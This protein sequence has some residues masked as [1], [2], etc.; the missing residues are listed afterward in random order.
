MRPILL[1]MLSG[2]LL[3][4]CATYY[5]Y[6]GQIYQ[7]TGG[8]TYYVLDPEGQ[9]RDAELGSD[10]ATRVIQQ[11]REVSRDEAFEAQSVRRDAQILLQPGTPAPSVSTTPN[12]DSGGY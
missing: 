3:A 8:S 11:G 7:R 6:Q 2:L 12:E 5:E 10:E 4:G 1:L 9:W